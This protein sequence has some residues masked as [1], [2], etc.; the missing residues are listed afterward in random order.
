[1]IRKTIL[2]A[3]LAATACS[4]PPPESPSEVTVARAEGETMRA[5][6]PVWSRAPVHRAALITQDMVEPRLLKASTTSV[7][8]QAVSDGTKLVLRLAW[9]DPTLDDLPGAARFFDAC[10]VQF[11]SGAAAELP[12]P[13]M[14]EQ[15]GPVEMTYW[16]AAWQATVDGRPDTIQALYPGAA[17]DHYPFEAPEL[18][19]DS[20]EREEVAGLYAPARALGNRMQGP[21]ERPVQD[22]TAQGPGTLEPAKR[23]VSEGRGEH[24]E[25]GWVVLLERPLPAGLAPGARTQVAFAVWQGSNREV[26]ARKMRTVWIPIVLEESP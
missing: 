18:E 26:G 6:H 3:L 20:P 22:L 17:V 25:S 13:Q 23:Q 9:E 24:G 11:P 10:A 5:D 21:R 19:P 12:A 4:Q 15:G 1:M 16:S 8:V 2:I 7:R 14:G